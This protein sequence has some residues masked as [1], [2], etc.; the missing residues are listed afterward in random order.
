MKEHKSLSCYVSDNL[1]VYYNKSVF[2]YKAQI[3]N[4]SYLMTL[5]A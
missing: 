2:I 3:H 1:T 4:K 5:N